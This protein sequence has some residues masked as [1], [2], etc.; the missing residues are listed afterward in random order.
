MIQEEDSEDN[1]EPEEPKVASEPK[2][3]P[4]STDSRSMLS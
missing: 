1:I 3:L 4:E 2:I